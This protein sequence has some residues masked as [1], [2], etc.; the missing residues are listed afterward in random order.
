MN[1]RS[2]RS[3]RDHV[4][5]RTICR[6]CSMPNSPSS[7]RIAP[8]AI[9]SSAASHL[10]STT[11]AKCESNARRGLKSS[12]DVAGSDRRFALRDDALSTL[13]SRSARHDIMMR[14][15]P[16]WHERTANRGIR[17][18]GI[19]SQGSRGQSHSPAATGHGPI[20]DRDPAPFA[21]PRPMSP[22]YAR[23][24]EAHIPL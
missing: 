5:P 12:D 3:G 19:H 18:R 7:I 16:A 11:P 23:P 24:P 20:Q 17:S 10:M 4:S 1:L 13:P 15:L 8:I 9:N 14:R 21:P 22:E 6:T 2:R